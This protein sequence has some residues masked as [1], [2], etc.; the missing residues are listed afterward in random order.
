MKIIER[1]NNLKKEK[2]I[3]FSTEMV[4]A[5][6]GGRKTQTRSPVS[7]S[8]FLKFLTTGKLLQRYG[9]EV[10]WVRETWRP[11]VG[12][13]SVSPSKIPHD[14]E[15]TYLEDCISHPHNHP[16]FDMPYR[17]KYDCS[18]WRPSIHMPR[19]FSRINLAVESVDIERLLDITEADAKAEGI[20]S[21]TKDGAMYKYGMVDSDGYPG[22]DNYGCSWEDFMPTATEAF[23]KLWNS[24]YE[25]QGFGW[26]NNPW[27]W[28]IKFKLIN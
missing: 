17:R 26:D 23:S 22:N 5:I 12:Y 8:D 27:V 4:R 21:I 13:E 20:A 10:L 11:K 15:I 19:H 16:V 28:V 7:T 2:P 6:L 25:E 9:A 18:K 1:W 3:L 24:I 14:E